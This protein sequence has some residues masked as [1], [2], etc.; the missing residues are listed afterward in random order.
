[1]Y[2]LLQFILGRG[3]AQAGLSALT[4]NSGVKRSQN[5]AHALNL[6]EL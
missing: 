5:G 6:R 2:R 3:L 4:T 1:M